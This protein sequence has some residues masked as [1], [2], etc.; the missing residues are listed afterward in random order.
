MNRAIHRILG[1]F[2][3]LLLLW[4]ASTGMGMQ[5]LDLKAILSHES[6]SAR[7]KLSMQE[8]MYGP[9]NFAVIQVSDF[10]APA[11]IPSP[12]RITSM[13]PPTPISPP[14]PRP[15]TSSFS[16]RD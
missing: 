16:G 7:Q 4:I 14:T 6:P 10:T 13:T 1:I 3:A 11:L 5:V 15:A 9:A 12:K 8:G 2:A